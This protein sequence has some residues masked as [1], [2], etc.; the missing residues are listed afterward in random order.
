MLLTNLKKNNV[1]L[2]TD[3]DKQ[4]SFNGKMPR[5]IEFT[6]L[7]RLNRIINL[8]TLGFKFKNFETNVG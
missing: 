4:Y 3:F 7:K 5:L 6:F 8:K 2:N 1:K